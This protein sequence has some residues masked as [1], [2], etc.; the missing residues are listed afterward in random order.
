[1]LARVLSRLARA[2]RVE[3]IVLATSVGKDDDPVAA[4]GAELGVRVVRG[5][6][7]DVLSRYVLAARE[8]EADVIIRVTADCP[9]ID[10]ALVD[11]VVEAFGESP[12]AWDFAANTLDRTYPRGLDVEV[13]HRDALRLADT[14]AQE[15]YERAHVMPFFYK[16]PE[17]F[18]LRSV[19]G[20]TDLSAHRWTV[21][22]EEDLAVVRKIYASLNRGDDFSWRD[23]MALVLAHPELEHDNAATAQ[24]PL[25]R[26]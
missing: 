19:R 23:V 17:R 6:E 8:S 26:G 12:W 2:Q 21:D 9:L 5:S 11:D 16:H 22:T 3:E 24:K 18:R 20:E 15:P 14:E 13:T 1:M 10:G 7:I 25:E 4:L